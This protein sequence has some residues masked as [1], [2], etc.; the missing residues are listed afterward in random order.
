MEKQV[1]I[2]TD[3]CLVNQKVDFG[4][5]VT[6]EKAIE[7]WLNEEYSDILDFDIVETHDNY[8]AK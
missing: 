4:E 3:M 1:W 5:K 8:G 6:K 7:M 2:M